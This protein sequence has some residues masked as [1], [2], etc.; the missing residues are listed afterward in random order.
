MTRTAVGLLAAAA[1]VALF[2]NGCHRE[3]GAATGAMNVRLQWVVQSQFAGFVVADRRGFYRDEGL[4]VRLLPAGPDLKPYMT[5]AAGSDQ[6]GIGVPNQI[7]LARSQG[8]PL[9]MIGQIFQESANRYVLKARNRIDSLAQ[10]R[11]RKVGLWLGGD[12]AEFVAMLKTAGM[13]L[14]DVQVVPEGYSVIPF[15]HD[16]YVLSEVTVYNELNL[17]RSMGYRDS[18]LQILNP[19]QFNAAILGDVVFTTERILHDR[20]PEIVKFLAA[21]LRGWQFCVDHRDECLRVVLA[22]N[23]ELERQEQSAQLNSVLEL[24]QGGA[25]RT[26]GLGYMDST[27]YGTAERV[28]MVSGQLE[29]AVT[30]SSTYDPSVWR[31]ANLLLR[32][33]TAGSDGAAVLDLL[34]SPS[35]AKASV[36]VPVVNR[37]RKET[38][39]AHR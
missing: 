13:S 20:R 21:S 2:A 37:Q 1:G 14:K 11:G 18:D 8:V 33:T 7:I 5:V 32:G 28:L 12:E 38:V 16:E 27:A 35:V 30:L 3:S 26:N 34:R 4:N 10:L 25:A 17:I 39:A 22:A 15:L 6:I 24:V 9:V 31:D 36:A 19:S 23:P 29:R